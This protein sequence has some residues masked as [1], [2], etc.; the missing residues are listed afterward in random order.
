M[1]LAC[2]DIGSNTTRLLVADADPATGTLVPVMTERV[3]LPLTGLEAGDARAWQRLG[4][5]EEAVRRL[6]AQ[7]RENGAV[8]TVALA[9]QALRAVP[10]GER[11]ALL[12]RLS[13]A[14]GVPV[15]LLTP[16]REA[17][18]AFAG[19]TAALPAGAAG[20]AVGV[21]DVGGGSTE[22]ITG[23]AG[24][25]P[26]WWCSVPLGSRVLTE[27]HLPSDPPSTIELAAATAVAEAALAPYRPPGTPLRVWT[28]GGGTQSVSRLLDGRPADRRSLSDAL[29]TVT[30]APAIEVAAAHGLDERRTS[31]LPAALILLRAATAALGR[32]AEPG[33]GGVR[34]GA[35]AERARLLGEAHYG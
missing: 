11:E 31:L 12:G 9:T 30:A 33:A 20:A 6:S 14:A 23:P 24:E 27:R 35:I 18:L 5:L 8:A 17:A 7:A 25:T 19:A 29:Q 15:E 1:R 2:L 4:T 13:D 28:V 26:A 16:A 32:A 10:D 21:I 3:F 22:L 34:E